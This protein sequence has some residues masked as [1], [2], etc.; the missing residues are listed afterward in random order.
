MKSWRKGL[1]LLGLRKLVYEKTKHFHGV[2]FRKPSPLLQSLTAASVA[3]GE[4]SSLES[5]FYIPQDQDKDQEGDKEMSDQ[6]ETYDADLITE[7]DRECFK[8]AFQQ[9][10][11]FDLS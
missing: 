3:E 11:S 6:G 5:L 10:P 9:L 7:Q 1:A 2:I 8:E 4:G